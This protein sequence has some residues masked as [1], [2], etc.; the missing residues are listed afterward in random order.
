[1][2]PFIG[3][4]MQPTRQGSKPIRPGVHRRAGLVGAGAARDSP[5]LDATFLW[6]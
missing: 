2:S 1:M 3:N 6:A 5:E 4:G